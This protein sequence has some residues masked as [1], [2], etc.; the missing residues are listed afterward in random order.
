[1]REIRLFGSEGGVALKPPSLPLSRRP[2]SA[3]HFRR[4]IGPFNLTVQRSIEAHLPSLVDCFTVNDAARFIA[5]DPPGRL[6]PASY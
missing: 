6:P 1:M 4:V 2:Q 5:A 3:L